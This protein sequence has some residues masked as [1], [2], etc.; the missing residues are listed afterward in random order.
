MSVQGATKALC[1]WHIAEEQ[2]RNA[3]KMGLTEGPGRFWAAT[4]SLI[5][6][7]VL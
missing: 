6:C 1:R 4:A 7:V 5:A 2:R 3:L